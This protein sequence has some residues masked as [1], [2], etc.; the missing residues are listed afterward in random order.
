MKNSVPDFL[1]DQITCG[2]DLPMCPLCDP[3]FA[4]DMA[5]EDAMM[6][7]YLFGWDS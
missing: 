1:I 7:G 6:E 4:F 5:R 3:D 2:C